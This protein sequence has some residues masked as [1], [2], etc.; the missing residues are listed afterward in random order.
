MF[1]VD[2]L[3]SECQAARSDSEPVLAVR[4]ALQRALADPAA[5]AEALPPERAGVTSLYTSET[6]TVLQFVWGPGMTLGPHDH[7]MWAAI[8]IYTAG[9]DNTFFRRQDETIVESG[10][11]ELRVGDVCL[12]GDDVIH[13]VHNPTRQ[14]TGAIHVYGGDF[15]GQPRSEWHGPPYEEHPYDVDR[16][17]ALFEASNLAN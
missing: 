2:S 16:I 12:L 11:R 7:R 10:G 14:H 5:I 4:E 3:I 15:F 13:A 8:G 6:L 17:M 1:D 9:E